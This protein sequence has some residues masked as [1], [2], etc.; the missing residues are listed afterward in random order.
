MS[1]L[2]SMVNGVLSPLGVE[3]H[4]N[5]ANSPLAYTSGKLLNASTEL[6]KLARATVFPDLPEKNGRQELMVQLLGTQLSE[7]LHVVAHLNRTLHLEGDVC[8]FG[9]AQ[10]ATSALIANEIRETNKKLWLFDS[11]EGLPRPTEQDILIDD[12]FNLGSIEKYQGLMA[13]GQDQVTGRLNAINFP[14]DRVQIVP[15]FIEKTAQ[16]ASLPK[17]VCFAYVDFDFYEPIKIALELLESRL[18]IGGVMI[19]DDYGFFSEGAK[20][21]VDEFV[22]A[23]EL[24][25]K[26]EPSPEWASKF[27][28]LRR[29]N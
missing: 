26:K 1:G 12:I 19:V 11:F 17:Q 5:G 25:Y 27:C 28:V 10:G 24:C 20:T 22:A 9:V 3:L 23:R 15:G 29:L 14:F 2:K 4:S 21:A 16:S 8:E 6:E 18:P 7:A 13:S